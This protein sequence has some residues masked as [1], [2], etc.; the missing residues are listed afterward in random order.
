MSSLFI[1]NRIFKRKESDE[2]NIVQVKFFL[3]FDSP[4]RNDYIRE[5]FTRTHASYQKASPH[6][7][8]SAL[9]KK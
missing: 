6:W 7:S 5:L 8:M 1:Q 9:V 2:R 3:I 4:I